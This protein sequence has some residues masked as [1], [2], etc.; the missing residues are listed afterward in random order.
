MNKVKWILASLAIL[1]FQ[2]SVKADTALEGIR[3][4][5]ALGIGVIDTKVDFS[6]TNLPEAKDSTD[7]SG[8]GAI[9]GFTIDWMSFIGNSNVVMGVEGSF[10]FMT[11]KGKKSTNGTF[12][13]A[14]ATA[15]LS[16]TVLFRR[17]FDFVAK[18]VYMMKDIAVPYVK[19]GPSMG[20]WKATSFSNTVNGSGVSSEDTL[21]TII[22]VGAD[23]ILTDRISFGADYDYRR[24]KNQTHTFNCCGNVPLRN[25]TVSPTAHAI[26][27]H[28]KYKVSAIDFADTPRKKK[29]RKRK[30]SRRPPRR[31]NRSNFPRK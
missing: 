9:A 15:D 22:G 21:G 28:L 24:Y 14:P 10:N 2:D 20:R 13:N 3:A 5:L 1:S 19:A 4:G 7:V 8:G 18:I 17:S 31:P 6:R 29:I 16:T 27:F 11:T 12:I 23:F 30:R 25:V 26:M